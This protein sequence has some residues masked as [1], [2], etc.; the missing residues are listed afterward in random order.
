MLRT[1]VITA[2]IGV[3]AFLLLIYLG[4]IWLALPVWG[5]AFLALLEYKHILQQRQIYASA[6]VMTIV[7]TL[8]IVG[9]ETVGGIFLLILL[10]AILPCLFLVAFCLRRAPDFLSLFFTIGGVVYIGVGF[11][12]LRLLRSASFLH[13]AAFGSGTFWVWFALLGTWMSDTGAYFAGK[14][15]GTKAVVPQISPHKTLEGFIGGAL[16]T[17]VGLLIY[18]Y[19]GQVPLSFALGLAMAVAMVAPAGDLFESL[20]KRYVNVKDSG[21]I[22]PG[23]GGI[24][25]RFDSLLFVTPVLYSLLL[26][27][28]GDL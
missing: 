4:G 10:P 13:G 19:A 3:A 5:L 23:H 6:I 9:A 12:T 18:A 15:F 25:D 11:S 1:R 26:F 27:L 20:L 2:L 8:M 7:M 16:F 17:I 24:L 28:I 22:L 21:H 14:R